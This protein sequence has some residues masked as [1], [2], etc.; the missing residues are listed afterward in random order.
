MSVFMSLTIYLPH[1]FFYFTGF[2]EVLGLNSG[3]TFLFTCLGGWG[4]AIHGNAWDPL[5]ALCSGSSQGTI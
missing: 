5:P 1:Y 3:Y 2:F 4:G